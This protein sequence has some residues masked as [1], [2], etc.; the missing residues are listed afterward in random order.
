[1]D[2]KNGKKFLWGN[3]DYSDTNNNN[4]NNNNLNEENKSVLT[5][6]KEK[7]KEGIEKINPSELYTKLKN[8]YI[9]DENNTKENKNYN[10][11]GIVNYTP[12]IENV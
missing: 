10:K 1:M 4:K 12:K 5:P 11:S 7:I 2:N 3:Y 6:I 8:K 9:N